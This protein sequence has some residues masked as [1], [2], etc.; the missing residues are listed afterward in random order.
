MG[1]DGGLR[2]DDEAAGDSKSQPVE[3]SGSAGTEGFGPSS[4]QTVTGTD[5]GSSHMVRGPMVGVT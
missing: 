3:P 2:V 4:R 5:E 1:F